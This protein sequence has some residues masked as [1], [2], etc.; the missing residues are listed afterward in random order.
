MQKYT[1]TC[2][3]KDEEE[4]TAGRGAELQGV[5]VREL[6]GG[7]LAASAAAVL[8]AAAGGTVPGRT[9]ALPGTGIGGTTG[10]GGNPGCAAAPTSW[11]TGGPTGTAGTAGV[12]AALA[13]LAG[14]SLLPRGR[15]LG[16]LASTMPWTLLVGAGS[17]V[18]SF[19]GP[20][21]EEVPSRPTLT[22]CICVCMCMCVCACV[23]VCARV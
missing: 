17:P 13:T 20:E 18:A 4:D 6:G 19:V 7:R 23:C 2:D 21:A 12:A 15:V 11:G 8:A 22:V 9:A 1:H 5:R 14:R 16:I 3:R 10:A